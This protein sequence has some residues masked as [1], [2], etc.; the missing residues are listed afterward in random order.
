MARNLLHNIDVRVAIVPTDWTATTSG[1]IIDRN[2]YESIV[3][4]I[5]AGA[6]TA[7]DS[8]NYFTFTI[9]E[10]DDSALSDAATATKVDTVDSWDKVLN[11]AGETPGT[12]EI[13]YYGDKRYCRL[14]MTETATAQCIVGAVAILGH[15]THGPA[16]S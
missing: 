13:S 16:A 5:N 2:G 9:Q 3:F 6:E 14:V 11:A 8:S 12:Y 1:A 7:L 4:Q 15:A 10:G